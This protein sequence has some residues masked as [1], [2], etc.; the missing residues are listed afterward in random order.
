MRV[1]EAVRFLRARVSPIEL[2]LLSSKV[3][4]LTALHAVE[5][6]DGNWRRIQEFR[7][8]SW[9]HNSSGGYRSYIER[10]YELPSNRK[11]LFRVRHYL[12]R[13]DI[14]ALAVRLGAKCDLCGRRLKPK[15][16]YASYGIGLF[17]INPAM[18]ACGLCC[19]EGEVSAA[20]RILKREA[21]AHLRFQKKASGV[22]A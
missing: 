3:R 14:Q 8:S 4:A 19:Q 22:V 20:T 15:S 9:Y 1:G 17:E 6:F 21:L 5:I 12:R 2:Y 13:D 11:F 7:D 16:V 18:V 10:S